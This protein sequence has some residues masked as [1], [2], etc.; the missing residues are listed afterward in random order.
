MLTL[1]NILLPGLGLIRQRRTTIGLVIA[2]SY[3]LLLATAGAGAWAGWDV[4]PKWASIA[5]A[6]GA[7]AVFAIGQIALARHV[8]DRNDPA[9]RLHVAALRERSEA[10]IEQDR[11]ID[12]LLTLDTWLSEDPIS[13]EA[14]LL[15]GHIYARTGR[16]ERARQAYKRAAKLDSVGEY[17]AEIRESQ[18]ALRV[19]L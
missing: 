5:A 14:H 12:A 16:P 8:A 4:L 1:W 13:A 18:A 2:A 7:G 19:R 15:R 3:L 11:Y 10:H 9:W 6:A 17:A